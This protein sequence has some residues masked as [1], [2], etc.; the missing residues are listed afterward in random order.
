MFTISR[1]CSSQFGTS[2]EFELDRDLFLVPPCYTFW[3]LLLNQIWRLPCSSSI[4]FYSIWTPPC[5]CSSLSTYSNLFQPVPIG[6]T[7]CIIPDFG[8]TFLTKFIFPKHYR[9]GNGV[10]IEFKSSNCDFYVTCVDVCCFSYTVLGL[11]WCSAICIWRGFVWQRVSYLSFSS[12]L[13]CTNCVVV[14]TEYWGSNYFH[15][16]WIGRQTKKL[17]IKCTTEWLS[18]RHYR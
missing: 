15:Y 17:E 8:E 12:L 4:L 2:G 10:C 1:P 6:C 5:S 3:L 14:I 13:F 9:V 11:N 18:R 16:Q 7:T